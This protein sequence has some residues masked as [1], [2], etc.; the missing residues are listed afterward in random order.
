MAD[1]TADCIGRAVLVSVPSSALRSSSSVA[2]GGSG[3]SF[4]AVCQRSG[5]RLCP[6][7]PLGRAASRGLG[8][9]P[10]AR[11][12]CKPAWVRSRMS[13]RPNSASAPKMWKTSCPV[14]LSVSIA[15]FKLFGPTPPLRSSSARETRSLSDQLSRSRNQTTSVSSA[16]RRESSCRRFGHSLAPQAVSSKIRSH[17]A[18]FS[19]SRCRSR[20]LVVSGDAGVADPHRSVSGN[21]WCLRLTKS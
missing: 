8:L 21:S 1:R 19:A 10:R 2:P 13:A 6:W 14:A 7:S 15:S 3:L 18:S 12:A 4:R 11:A 16:H 5:E 20:V 17:P 9:R